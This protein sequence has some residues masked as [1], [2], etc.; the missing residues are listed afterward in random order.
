MTK[1]LF[2]VLSLL[3]THLPIHA[4]P[5][6]EDVEAH[7][8]AFTGPTET[9]GIAGIE[10]RGVI[11]LGNEF[12]AMTGKQMRARVFTIEPGGVVA[13]HTHEQR[14]GYA[15]ILEGTIIEH[16]NDSEGPI[17]HGPNSIA[18]EKNGVSHWWENTSDQPVK[19]LVVDIFTPES[20]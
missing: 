13:V 2:L 20:N 15:F 5:V 10:T 18:I 9:K 11:D 12:S 4:H 14:P 16:R 1:R 8:H 19:A 6:G 7:T 3:I 17:I